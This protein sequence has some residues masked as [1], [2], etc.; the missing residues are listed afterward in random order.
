MQNTD[1]NWTKLG[2]RQDISEKIFHNVRANSGEIAIF[3][4]CT[5][6]IEAAV[7]LLT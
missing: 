5:C 4:T 3:Y 7:E 6:G 1:E 2:K